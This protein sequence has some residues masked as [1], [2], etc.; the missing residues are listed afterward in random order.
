[1]TLSQ[2]VTVNSKVTVGREIVKLHR[3]DVT[4]NQHKIVTITLQMTVKYAVKFLR[5]DHVTHYKY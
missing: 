4:V 3:D 2:S 5:N 1:V